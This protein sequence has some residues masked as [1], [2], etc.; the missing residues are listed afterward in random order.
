[1]H[2]TKIDWFDETIR[3]LMKEGSNALTIE[4]LTTGLGVTKGSFYHHFKN[5]EGFKASLLDYFQQ[6]GTQ[7]IINQVEEQADSPQEKLRTLM[8]ITC[9]Y[10]AAMETAIRAWALHDNAVRDYQAAVDTRRIAYVADLWLQ[11]VNAQMKHGS[12]PK[13]C[14]PF[15]SVATI[16]SRPSKAWIK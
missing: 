3:I 9:E 8:R 5:Y 13:C 10:P 14:I 4:R 12:V 2:K 15:S 11:L 16:P 7:D 1:M 6:Q